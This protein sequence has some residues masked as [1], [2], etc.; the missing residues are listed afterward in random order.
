VNAEP[1][2]FTGIRSARA[3]DIINSHALKMGTKTVFISHSSKDDAFVRKLRQALEDLGIEVWADSERLSGGDL[4]TSRIQRSIENVDHFLVVVSL[5]ALNSEWVPREIKHAQ[6]V[7]KDGYKII[8]IMLPGIEIAAMRLL[9]PNEPVAIRIGE[10]PAAVTEALPQILDA[11]GEQL[12]TQI[13]KHVQAETTPVSD[14]VLELTDPA[15]EYFE[16]NRRMIAIA[17]LTYCP[18]DGS[19]RVESPRYRFAAPLGPIETEEISW[20]L[21]SYI[22]WP[23]KFFQERAQRTIEA[24]PQWGRFLYDAINVDP[25]RNALEAWKSSDSA[26]RRFTVKVDRQ[27]IAGTPEAKQIEALES[28]TFLLSLPWE[29]IHDDRS[30]LFQGKRP[31]RVRRSLPN[32]DPQ[33]APAT[34]APLRVLLVSPRP[35]DNSARYIDHRSSARPLV[36]A[37]SQLAELASFKLL[38]PPTFAA[39]EAELQRAAQSGEAYHVVHFD[40]H[41]IYD[42]TNGLGKLCFEDPADTVKVEQRRSTLI[43][44]GEVAR[45]AREYRIPLFFLE[46]YQSAGTDTG[47]SASVAGGLLESGVSSVI[48]MSHSVLVETALRFITEFYKELLSGA[49]IG[50]AMLAGQRA[51]KSDTFR[52][53]TFAGELHLEDWFVPVL[54]QEEHDRQLIREVLPQQVASV[55]EK[56]KHLA[57]GALPEEPKHQFLGRSRDLLKAERILAQKRYLV[58]QGSG[59]EGKTTFAAELARWLVV[60]RRFAR[61]AFTSVE[62]IGAQLV[63]NF[64]SQVGTDYQHGLQ[65]LERALA[66]HATVLVID[67]VES[68]LDQESLD[69]ILELCETC[70]K[71]GQTRVIFTSRQALSTPFDGNVLR[72]GRLDHDA[73]IRL[74][75][76]LLPDAWESM[77]TRND[78]ENLVDAVNCHARSLVLIAREVGAVGV[79]QATDN[80]HGVFQAIEA[81]HP[82]ERENS[83]LASAAL[84][85]RRLPEETRQLIRPLR[86]FQGGG[87]LGAIRL[88]LRL[89][90]D[91]VQRCAHALIGVGLAEYVDPAYLRFDPALIGG[92]LTPEEHEAATRAWAAAV[93]SEVIFL[94]NEQFRDADYSNRLALLELPNFLAALVYFANSEP[95]ERVVHLATLLEQPISYVN[96]PKALARIVKIRSVASERLSGWSH[97]RFEADRA[98]IE[99][100]IDQGRTAEAVQA[101]QRLHLQAEAAGDG[102]YAA[103]A[104]DG[105][106]AQ[107][108]LGQALRISGN[109]AAALPHL[110]R[111]RERFER[112]DRPS[113][114]MVGMALAETASC[115]IDLGRYDEAASILQET[116]AMAADRDDLRA[117]AVEKSQLATVRLLQRNYE[118]ALRQYQETLE[119]FER[120]KEPHSVSVAWHQ[121]GMVH[122]EEGKYK[123]A[124]RAYQKALNIDIQTNDL[125]SQAKTLNQLGNLCLRSD[126]TE[127][128][129]RLYRQATEIDVSLGQLR[130]EGTDRNNIAIGLITLE[131]YDEARREL[132]RA[133]ECNKPFGHVARPWVTLHLLSLLERAVGNEPAAVIVRDQAVTAYLSYRRD[134]GASEVDAAELI[135]QL[136]QDSN[137]AHAAVSNLDT[138]CRVAAEIILAFETSKSALP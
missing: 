19:R 101:A 50:H 60:T 35:D 80:L 56:K 72:I 105:A 54:F 34:Q 138:E 53:K 121:I 92:D 65:L 12:P 17:K 48:A 99:R 14:L 47:S 38:Q 114:R 86:V 42:G 76:N 36:E 117:V 97:A 5:N 82:G 22:N 3:N 33:S 85:L 7:Q 59:G 77:D 102:A 29:L 61:A 20:Y 69:E 15:I 43:D 63:P 62:Q 55:I 124:E 45:V 10:G 118:D 78:L 28:T 119:V 111:A 128:A 16:G 123:A 71:V 109:A 79:R 41:G 21:E 91:D 129:V 24:L 96:R 134:G 98:A 46:A 88:A 81:K 49:R 90:H 11:L 132:E 116:I 122:Q 23:S 37:L 26:D 113:N 64:S 1:T 73:A 126:R 31:V 25:A 84:S 51:L 127:D 57:L 112:L 115:L 74:V 108:Y 83:L 9:F 137:D 2:H 30:Y 4:L 95:A 52:G 100:F 104:S 58:V 130:N 131:R 68:I 66:E 135:A 27:L 13:I 44:A 93:A 120:R 40:G 32:R 107:W 70:N 18:P 94:Y 103:A 106:E 67:N 136:K 133:I 110:E 89:D 6:S 75:G 87:S 125:S 39:F 8:P